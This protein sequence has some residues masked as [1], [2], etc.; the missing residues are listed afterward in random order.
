MLALLISS[1]FIGAAGFALAAI[2]VTERSHAGAWD[3]LAEER[4]TL[5]TR[6]LAALA[7]AWLPTTVTAQAPLTPPGGYR[8]ERRF[9]PRAG[10]VQL[11]GGLRA[12]A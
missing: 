1:F 11:P 12:A 7:E 2:V 9:M 3:R 6:D 8:Y 5:R 10:S 4:K